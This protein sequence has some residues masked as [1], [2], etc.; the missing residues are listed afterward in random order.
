M[1]GG[2][3]NG[4]RRLGVGARVEQGD[5][6][7]PAFPGLAYL[8]VGDGAGN[9]A[10]QEPGLPGSQLQAVP[11]AVGVNGRGLTVVPVHPFVFGLLQHER[12]HLRKQVVPPVAGSTTAC[13]DSPTGAPGRS[14]LTARCPTNSPPGATATH[15]RIRR[16]SCSSRILSG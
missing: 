8:L 5:R 12:L 11:L 9:E 6:T 7:A 14:T 2:R 1:G 4:S 13:P 10:K 3:I 16:P 15:E